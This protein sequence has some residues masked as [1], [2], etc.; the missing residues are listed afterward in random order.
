VRELAS[1]ERVAEW[2]ATQRFWQAW[3]RRLYPQQFV[4]FSQRWEGASAYFDQLSDAGAGIGRYEGPPVPEPY[5][6]ALEQAFPAVP[7]L[8]WRQE[9]VVQSVNLVSGRIPQ[10]SA[11]YQ[12]AAQ[13]LLETRVADETMLYRTLSQTLGQLYTP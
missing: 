4:A 2:A 5:I 7:G 10:E 1:G 9:G 13:L 12:R 8:T 11:I 6:A 3:L